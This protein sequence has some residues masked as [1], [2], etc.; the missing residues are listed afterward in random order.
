LLATAETLISASPAAFP[1]GT[2]PERYGRSVWVCER[3]GLVGWDAVT[4]GG[5]RRLPAVSPGNASD[6]VTVLSAA[7]VLA[8]IALTVAVMVATGQASF[9]NLWGT[10]VLALGCAAVGFVVIRRQPANPIGWLLLTTA[11]VDLADGLTAGYVL[12]CYRLGHGGLPLG[13]AAVVAEA[14]S[15]SLTVIFLPLAVLLFPDGRLLSRRWRSSARCGPAAPQARPLSTCIPTRPHVP[16]LPL[17]SPGWA[18]EL[19]ARPGPRGPARFCRGQLHRAARKLRP[20]W[21]LIRR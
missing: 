16:R 11:M 9:A 18:A 10:A 19:A 21:R 20:A 13:R 3:D 5:G 14:V 15:G 6:L 7:V 1:A 8:L 4:A 17:R 2:F 12:L